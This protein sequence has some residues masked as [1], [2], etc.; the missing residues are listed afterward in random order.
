MSQ[1]FYIIQCLL[2]PHWVWNCV[3]RYCSRN[4]LL[5][6]TWFHFLCVCVF[7]LP[8][9][10]TCPQERSSAEARSAEV[11]ALVH[12][13]TYWDGSVMPLLVPGSSNP[14]TP[15]APAM[16][17]F[18]LFRCSSGSE[19]ALFPQVCLILSAHSPWWRDT[20]EHG[21]GH[22]LGQSWETCQCPEQ[23]HSSYATMF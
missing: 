23:F 22:V 12:I 10:G 16:S 1:G 20:L 19:P 9:N 17:A 6:L 3:S 7:T 14:Q 2:P 18:P 15:Q 21:V 4:W 8:Y 11:G 5:S 13:T